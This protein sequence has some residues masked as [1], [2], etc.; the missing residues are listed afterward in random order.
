[1]ILCINLLIY[2]TNNRILGA[3]SPLTLTT[4]VKIVFSRTCVS[5]S[6]TTKYGELVAASSLRFSV[7]TT[8]I[9]HSKNMVKV[10]E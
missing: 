9:N 3:G 2:H 7:D 1:V 4:N 10:G 8:R 5:F 6:C